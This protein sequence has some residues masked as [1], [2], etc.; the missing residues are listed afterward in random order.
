MPAFRKRKA[1]APPS[2]RKRTVTPPAFIEQEENYSNG[3]DDSSSLSSIEE[4]DDHEDGRD[5]AASSPPNEEDNDNDDGEDDSS[6][7]SYTEED[8]DHDDDRDGAP[9][10]ETA[11]EWHGWETDSVETEDEPCLPC[12]LRATKAKGTTCRREKDGKSPGLPGFSIC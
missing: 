4:D 11:A 5:E 8:D 6:S 3:R 12:V 10:T 2:I 7:L 1:T 9:L